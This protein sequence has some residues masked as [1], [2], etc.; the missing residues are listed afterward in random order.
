ME[1]LTEIDT[2]GAEMEKIIEFQKYPLDLVLE[3]L[4]MDKTTGKPIIWATNSY[5]EFGETYCDRF[6]ITLGALRG[7]NPVLIQPRAFKTLETQHQR[8]K[9]KAEV[10][11]PSWVVNKMINKMDEEWFERSNVFNIEVGHTWKTN[12][13]KIE[14]K[15]KKWTDYV[16]RSVLEIACGEA[17]FIVSRYDASTGAFIPIEERVGILDRKLRIVTENTDNEIDWLKWTKRAFESVYGYEYQGDNLLIGRINLLMTFFDYYQSIWK[18]D[19]DK[20]HLTT[21]TNIITWNF[22]QMDGLYGTVPLGVPQ[23]VVEQLS[24][25]D[26]EE[27]QEGKAPLCKV[28]SWKTKK[29]ILYTQN[30]SP[31]HT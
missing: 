10:F 19:A 27:E 13:Q 31:F 3:K 11:T 12:S 29:T 26:D 16:N 8:T 15:D 5:S 9:S 4:L 18:K 7:M 20:S 24:L 6:I 1:D 2:G 30:F 21:M 22:W 23:P 14:F 28:K 25:F 17:P